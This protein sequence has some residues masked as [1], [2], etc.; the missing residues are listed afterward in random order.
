MAELVMIRTGGLAR[1]ADDLS[2]E[3]FGSLSNGSMFRAQVDAPRNIKQLRLV[4][5][6]LKKIVDNHPGFVGVEELKRELKRRSGMYQEF[7][8]RDGE[9]M[10]ELDSISPAV[11]DQSRFNEVWKRWVDLILRGDPATGVEPILAGVTDEQLAYEI[12]RS[13]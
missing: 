4:H 12:A 5:V 13:L 2:A 10:Y 11:M 1:P 3:R 7:I 9:V 8:S 6:L